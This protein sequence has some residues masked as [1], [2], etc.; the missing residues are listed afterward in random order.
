MANR[1]RF[2]IAE[3]S[4]KAYFKGATQK[5][6]ALGHLNGIL[7]EKRALWN[8]PASM[9]GDKFLEKLIQSQILQKCSI[10]LQGLDQT[11]NR[12]ITVDASVYQVAVSLISKS[13]LS[14]YTA[15]FLHGLT[16]QVPKVIYVSFEQSKKL[17]SKGTLRQDAIDGA[18]AKPQRKSA[19]VASYNDYTFIFHNGMYSNRAGV[20]AFDDIPVTNLERTLIDITVRPDYAGGVSSVLEAYRRAIEKISLNKLIAILDKF[21][22][23]Y[24]YHQSIGFYLERVGIESSRLQPLMERRM[25]FDFYLT[26]EMI[27]KEYDKS[28]RIYYPKG[29]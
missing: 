18:F 2:V 27:D 24:P 8:L 25:E 3:S 6:Y 17:Q 29:I 1:S 9:T 7:E 14:H 19:N 4:I 5:V 16:T 21:D 10:Y 28:W 23:T 20:A 26:Y 11:K 12:Y 22:F 15:V 13:F